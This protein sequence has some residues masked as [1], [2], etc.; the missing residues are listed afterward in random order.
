MRN[1]QVNVPPW[2]PFCG[3]NVE[4]PGF[5][6]ER[7]MMEFPLGRCQCGA[8][9]VSDPTGFNIG[10]AMIECLVHACGGNW[11][12]AWELL[13]EEDYL[14]G[15]IEDYDEQTHQ[16]VETRNLDG[17]TV[18]GVL[19]FVRLH[20][21]PAE[22]VASKAPVRKSSEV[23]PTIEPERDPKRIKKRASKQEVQEMIETGNVDGLVDLCFDDNR[24]IRFMQRLLYNPEEAT[25]WRIAHL[26]GQVC[27]RV[28][29]RKPGM[30]SDLLHR[31]FEACADSASASWGAVETI[32]SIIAA[33]PDIF[34]S[35]TRY[36]L[37]VVADVSTR[38]Q[39]VW[40]LGT[41]AEHRPDLIREL[42]FYKLF[43][44]LDH[45]DP[46]LRACAIRLLGRIRAKEVIR[47]IREMIDDTTPVVI[48]EQGQPV[49]TD[50]SRLAQE[51]ITLIEEQGEKNG[52]GKEPTSTD[53]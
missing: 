33:R 37:G 30:V 4:K 11:D 41:I 38:S 15:R 44:L 43:G 16:V 6:E 10:A 39:I 18:R 31:L 36:L 20:H 53:H 23:T 50:M 47:R 51:A 26:I 52:D 48:Y 25:R 34:G 46:D 8:V 42:P 22:L 14:T 17:R 7:K 49:K 35:F 9:Y 3:Q 28:S 13:P 40:A 24:T 29:T 21:D 45:P 2:C 5:P 32:G 19:Y 1:I 27:G 12:L